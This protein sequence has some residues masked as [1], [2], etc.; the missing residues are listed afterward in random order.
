MY[1]KIGFESGHRVMY[2]FSYKTYIH[3][4]I[5]EKQTPN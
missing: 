3:E 4:E 2:K 1:F 5:C